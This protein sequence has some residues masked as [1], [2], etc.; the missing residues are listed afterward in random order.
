[1]DLYSPALLVRY[2]HPVRVESLAHSDTFE[3]GLTAYAS[4]DHI[5]HPKQN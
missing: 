3:T 2:G 4:A 1:M 5:P